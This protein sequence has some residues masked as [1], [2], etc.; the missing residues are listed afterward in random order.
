LAARSRNRQRNGCS[1]Q[2]QSSEWKSS[3]PAGTRHRDPVQRQGSRGR[4]PIT[5]LGPR[6]RFRSPG[7]VQPPHPAAP[8][9]L[10]R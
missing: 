9:L 10:R 2:G 6:F 5:G 7:S 8:A 3:S 4:R 1:M